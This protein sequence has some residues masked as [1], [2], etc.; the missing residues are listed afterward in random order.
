[1]Q[2]VS[3]DAQRPRLGI[4]IGTLFTAAVFEP[5]FESGFE[6][7]SVVAISAD[8]LVAGTEAEAVIRLHPDRGAKEIKRRFGDT[9]PIVL[10]G[11]VFD[12]SVLTTELVRSV[13]LAS[14]V[15]PHNSTVNSV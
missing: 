12:P 2:S 6:I 1:M 5:A 14:G 11:G 3:N 15:D 13:T 4:D 9:T 10:D 8:Q 7:A